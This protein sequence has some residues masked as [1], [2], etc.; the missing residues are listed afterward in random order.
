MTAK[1]TAQDG[2]GDVPRAGEAHPPQPDVATD[3]ADA[4]EENGTAADTMTGDRTSTGGADAAAELQAAQDRHLRLAAEYDNYRK[5]TE[6]ERSESWTRAQAQ[7]VERLLEP[8][9]DL[10]R[11]AHFDPATTSAGSLLEG[12]QLVERKLLRVLEAAGLDPVEAEGQP[13]DPAIHEALAS[14]AAERPDEDDTVADVFQKGYRLKGVLL[15][16]ARVRVK[17]YEG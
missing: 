13:F 17:K 2:S 3:G 10:Q 15:R 1:R 8:L 6:R 11:V 9:D 5:R 12:V 4:G 14:T 16:P 7:L